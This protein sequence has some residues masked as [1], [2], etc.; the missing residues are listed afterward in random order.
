VH[1]LA[2]KVLERDTR[3]TARVCRLVDD[4][5][6]DYLTILKDL[7]PHTASA[8][9]VGVTGNPGAGKST[10]T[11]RLIAACRKRGERVAVVAVDPTSPF[12]GGAILGDRI[13]MQQH[14]ADPDVFIRSLATR[15]ALGGLTRSAADVVRVLDAWGADV[16]LVETVGVGQ[17]ELEITRMA[18]TTVVVMAPGLGDEVQ[19]IKAGILEC[20]DVFAVNK[21][22]R[23]GAD[24]T[25]RDLELMIALGGEVTKAGTH[26]RSHQG[27]V[28]Q[29]VR[30]AEGAWVPLIV[31]TVA[32]RNEGTDELLSMLEKH[33]AWLN[34]TEPGAAR[35]TTRLAE[36]LRA[37]LREALIDEALRDLGDRLDA[38]VDEVARRAIDPYTAAERL[39]AEFRER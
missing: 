5:T 20:A 22:D 33:R 15:G 14:A 24:G 21:A 19:A 29:E 23:E 18:Q 13:R 35:R 36:A 25:M 9:V 39:V 34:T 1:P 2:Q 3:A 6:G 27:L 38:A 8:W 10:L 11:D 30:H 4:R 28:K 16:V 32:T 26:S 7:F 17:D 31:R 12:S 37:H